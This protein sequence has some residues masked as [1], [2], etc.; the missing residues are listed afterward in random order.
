MNI[1]NNKGFSLIEIM[2][3]LGLIVIIGGI[4]TT[5]YANYTVKALDGS[6]NATMNAITK[7]V[8]VCMAVDNDTST[9]GEGCLSDDVNGSITAN[10]GLK[11]IHVDTATTNVCYYIIPDDSWDTTDS[12]IK[13]DAKYGVLKF[14]K[15]TAKRQPTELGTAV[16]NKSLPPRSESAAFDPTSTC[17]GAK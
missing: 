14:A 10:P 17:D 11:I 9:T 4:A 16:A 7:A 8:G 6:I 13:A 15:S 2:V 12:E 1:K 5:Q 3:A